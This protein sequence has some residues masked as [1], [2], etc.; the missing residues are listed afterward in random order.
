M[1]GAVKKG[2]AGGAVMA[3]ATVKQFGDIDSVISMS[4]TH[5]KPTLEL[6]S[7]NILIKVKACSL[8]PGDCRMI[9]G[10]KDL[11]CTPEKCGTT[12]PYIPGLDVCGTVVEVDTEGDGK[13]KPAERFKVGDEIIGTWDMVGLGGMAE[14]ALVKAKCAAVIPPGLGISAVEAAALANSASHALF[15]FER[16]QIKAGER[17]LLIGGSGGV[18]T[19]LTQLCKDAGA[20]Y[21]ACVSTDATLMTSLGADRV[22]DYR[23]EAWADVAAA[24]R[25]RFDVVVD[26]AQGVSAWKQVQNQRILKVGSQGGRFVSVVY[27]EWHLDIH[28][29]YALAAFLLPPLFRMISSWFTRWFTP[30]YRMYLGSADGPSIERVLG[31]VAQKRLK[32]VVDPRG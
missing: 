15:V 8:S 11:F 20:A 19:A 28:S 23:Q 7:G 13:T 9:G 29:Y 18:G 21:V 6:K 25:E 4:Y 32:A 30:E 12:W 3:A 10:H 2:A 16:A 26:C 27:T 31:L 17:V 24:E 1:A 14:F 22:V 5:P